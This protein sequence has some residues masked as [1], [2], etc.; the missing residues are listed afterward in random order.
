VFLHYDQDSLDA[1]YNNQAK[2]GAAAFSAFVV[3]CQDLS[4][5][6]RQD[7]RCIL[8]LAYGAT[9]SETLDVFPADGDGLSPVEVFFHG[10]YWRL[11]DKSDFSY[12]SNGFVPHGRTVVIVNYGLIPHVTLDEI[13]A[14]CRRAMRWVKDNIALYG[15]DADDIS[16]SGHSAGGHLVAMMLTTSSGRD[17]EDA[18][19]IRRACVISGLFD[20]EPIRLCYLNKTLALDRATVSRNSPVYLPPCQSAYLQVVVGGREGPEY[21]RQSR[22]LYDAWSDRIPTFL[23][24]LDDDHF[25]IRAQLNEAASLL[26]SLMMRSV[27]PSQDKAMK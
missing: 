27:P 16:L 13:V 3:E 6:A 19:P 23:T 10:G 12:V 1:Q 11:L 22:L 8:D 24:V 26:I 18:V 2:I 21:L 4:A 5:Q 9:N 15:G 20:L 17:G 25:T 7:R 14:Q